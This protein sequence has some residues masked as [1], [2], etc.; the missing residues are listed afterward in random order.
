MKIGKNVVSPSIFY[1]WLLMLLAAPQ[2][3]VFAQGTVKDA[4]SLEDMVVTSTK[5]EK[6][7]KNLIDPVTIVTEEEITQGGFT[8]FTEVL[9][10]T[11]NIEFKRSGGPGQYSYMKMRGLTD[12]YMLVLIDGVLMNEAGGGVGNLIARLDPYL[13][14][15][16]E[17]LRGT[18]SSLYG[19]SA[20]SG[21]ISITTKGGVSGMQGTAGAEYGN[22]KW[23]K[24]YAS[25]RGT[26]GNFGY[27]I[28]VP[29]IDSDGVQDYEEYKNFSPHAKL[30]Y[31]TDVFDFSGSIVYNDFKNKYAQLEESNAPDSAATPWW[32]FEYPD[33]DQYNKSERTIAS[34]TG[35]HVIN[36]HLSHKLSLGYTWYESEAGDDDN[37][38]LGYYRAPVDNF[39]NPTDSSDDHEYSKGELVPI[40]DDGNGLTYNTE[41][42]TYLADYNFTIDAHL[43]NA[44]QNIL[45]LGAEYKDQKYEKWGKY[46]EA[47]SSAD[48]VSG[49][50]NDQ[51]LLLDESLILSGGLRYDDHEEFGGETTYK[52]G[53]SYHCPWHTEIYGNYG[54]SF[55]APSFFQLYDPNYGNEDLDPETGENYEI[56]LRQD[57]FGGRLGFELVYFDIEVDDV[58]TYVSNWPESGGSYTNMD[59]LESDGL[60]FAFNWFIN[61]MFRL[62]GN[63]A[64]T[65][66]KT[67]DVGADG[68]ETSSR[69]VQVARNKWN[70]GL[71]FDRDRYHF[72]VNLYYSDPRLR[73]KGDIEMDDY[74]R[75]DVMGRVNLFNGIDLYTRIQNL[76]DEDIE[77]GMAYEEPGFYGIV[78][79]A[80][81][82]DFLK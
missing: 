17:I 67:I 1:I 50:I 80:Y 6:S 69:T 39:S 81:N 27:G 26:E 8:D 66:S 62:R 28:N 48:N 35:K 4:E 74:Y 45:L 61:D 23:T 70:L 73:W 52:V 41:T 12:T 42:K 14:E 37:G 58:V 63:Y 76:F 54:T 60:E 24:G 75:V 53:A 36:E 56:G 11:P 20:V 22:L 31:T 34:V 51:L 29:Y 33:P 16:V 68:V 44:G 5:I 18:Q 30:T 7:V 19:S 13:I 3:G 57:L 25:L 79:L 40:W 10:Y 77:E 21:V 15:K 78:G 38:L 32:G 71:Y 43:G 82:A 55:K 47:E 64:Y 46:G 65:D 9:R 2:H 59:K 49:Y 72:G